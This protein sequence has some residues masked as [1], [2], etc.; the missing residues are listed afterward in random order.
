MF[1]ASRTLQTVLHLALRLL[2]VLLLITRGKG[3]NNTIITQGKGYNNTIDDELG[4]N[5]TG[6]FPSYNP[7]G[8]WAQGNT[9][10]NCFAHPDPA[11]AYDHS[12]FNL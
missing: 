12:E 8:K 10:S 9:C 11:L 6:A 7:P 3:Y 5:V 2:L 4:D 1:R